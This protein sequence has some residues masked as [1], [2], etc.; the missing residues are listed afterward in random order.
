MRIRQLHVKAFGSISDRPFDNLSRGL[1]IVLGA[2]EAGKSTLFNLVLALQYGFHPVKD[3]PYWPWHL[4]VY[5]EFR[6][7]LELDAGGEAEVTRKLMSSPQTTLMWNGEHQELANRNLPSVE[8]VSKDLYEAVYAPTQADLRSLP[9]AR[10]QEIEDRLLGG[11]G[12]GLLRPTRDVVSEIQSEAAQLWRPDRRG[13]PRHRELST[14]RVGIRKQRD[15]AKQADEQ[16]RG[17]AVRLNEVQQFIGNLANKKAHIAAEL[18][19]ADKLRPLRTRLNQIDEWRSRIEH[20]EAVRD[21]PQGLETEHKRLSQNIHNAQGALDGLRSDRDKLVKQQDVFAEDDKAILGRADRIEGWVKRMSAHQRDRS[22]LAATA[23]KARELEETLA[24]TAR[25]VLKEPWDESYSDVVESL[26]F[27]DLKTAILD[28]ADKEK[29]AEAKANEVRNLGTVRVAGTLPWWMPSGAA[30]LGCLVII[31]GAMIP[32]GR[33]LTSGVVLVLIGGAGAAFNL[34]L[35]SQRARHAE[36]QTTEKEKRLDEQH[37]AEAR[38]DQVRQDAENALGELPVAQALLKKPDLMLY[39]AVEKLHSIASEL[40][41]VRGQRSESEEQWQN[42]QDDLAELLNELGYESATPETLSHA[43]ARLGDARNHRRTQQETAERVKEIDDALPEREEDFACVEKERDQF[44]AQLGAAVGKDMSTEDL[45]QRACELQRLAVQIRNSDEELRREYPDLEELAREIEQHE[46]DPDAWLF[47]E[48]EVEKQRDRLDVI[49]GELDSL[50]EEKGQLETELNAARGQVSV[51]EL[52]GEIAQ[53]EEKMD[54]AARRRDRLMLLACLLQEA[55]RR[56]REE[57]QPDVL[58]R[59]SDYLRTITCGRYKTLT[60]MTGEDGVE[61]L[62]IVTQDGET[63]LVEHPLSGGTLDQVFLSFRFA[64]IDHLDEG[65][66]TLPL[67]LDEALINWDDTRLQRAG[68]ILKQVAERRQVFL[69]TCHP[70][71]AKRLADVTGALV[72]E[73]PT[74]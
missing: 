37:R 66:E 4:N 54:E 52:D 48:V 53:I 70:W 10:R 5:P 46:G 1:V 24:D 33:L 43:G 34:H 12:A 14:T 64:V 30:G 42:A 50:R 36:G 29:E 51:G 57:H 59:A 65:H 32:S 55:D 15:D 39:Q 56:F 71:L 72:C 26:V 31:L 73:L 19:R 45:L 11:L 28:F 47:D 22:A 49:Q 7:V 41:R 13:S 62:I 40:R 27:P 44:L 8:H 61:R 17:K 35:R 63:H 21:L 3:F 20:I 9:E 2:N 69:F 60:T 23:Q 6:A 16:V 25:T 38:R 67:L 68:D 18:H 74:E 58:K